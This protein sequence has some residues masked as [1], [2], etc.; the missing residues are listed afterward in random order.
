M[1]WEIDFLK[2]VWENL[3]TPAVDWFMRVFTL[4]G[5]VAFIYFVI[6]I[7]MLFFKKTRK[8]GIVC[9]AVLVLVAGLNIVA[10]KP[11]VKRPRPFYVDETLN[12][13]VTTFFKNTNFFNHYPKETAYSFMS[14]H[15]LSSFLFATVVSL[16]H[17]KW[18]VPSFIF[19][20]LMS[21]TR[22]YFAFHYPTDIIAG[23][24]FG[25]IFGFLFVLLANF[26][27]KKIKIKR[28]AKKANETN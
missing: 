26:I 17:P 19:A 24:V 3:H 25:L 8:T 1:N 18:L 4:L 11:L 21:F 28:Q 14:G 15:A 10:V 7:T 22:L 20:S 12:T 23:A 27:E 2:W 9:I 5:D 6:S 16:Y 13:Y